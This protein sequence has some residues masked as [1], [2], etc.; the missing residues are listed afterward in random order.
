MK[1]YKFKTGHINS[2]SFYLILP[3]D[4]DAEPAKHCFWWDSGI[5]SQVGTNSLLFMK[6]WSQRNKKHPYI[7]FQPHAYS[8]PMGPFLQREFQEVAALE[9]VL[10]INP[11]IFKEIR[12]VSDACSQERDCI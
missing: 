4:T 11:N 7:T 5:A 3:Y 2:H 1:Y 6:K 8:S 12:A 10:T 9:A